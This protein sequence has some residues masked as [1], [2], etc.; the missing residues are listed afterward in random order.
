MTV[1][2]I[3]RSMYWGRVGTPWESPD[4]ATEDGISLRVS[5]F[6]A[7]GMA[8]L[9]NFDRIDDQPNNQSDEDEVEHHLNG[10]TDDKLSH[11]AGE[12]FLK[13]GADPGDVVYVVTQTKGHIYLDRVLL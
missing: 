7:R 9:N 3:R 12:M 10:R 11:I 4:G 2:P 8:A 6:T 5:D 13:R 1:T